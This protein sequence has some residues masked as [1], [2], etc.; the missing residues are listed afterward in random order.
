MPLVGVQPVPGQVVV[1]V[2]ERVQ[3]GRYI[4]ASREQMEADHESIDGYIRDGLGLS[5]D[6]IGQLREQLLTPATGS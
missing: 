2:F 6:D 1:D 3:D 4:D 5:G